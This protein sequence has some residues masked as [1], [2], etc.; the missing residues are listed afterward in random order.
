MSWETVACCDDCS[1]DVDSDNQPTVNG[2]GVT[3]DGRFRLPVRLVQKIRR[4]EFCHFCGWTTYSGAYVRVN[5][6][7]RPAAPLRIREENP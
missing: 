5:T 4:E 2:R 1:W 6:E 3:E 7:E